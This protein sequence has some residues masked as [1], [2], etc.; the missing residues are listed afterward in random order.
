M[1]IESE[2]PGSLGQ[3]APVVK[4]HVLDARHCIVAALTSMAKEKLPLVITL[5]WDLLQL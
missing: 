4:S 3:R 2:I 5:K 1:A